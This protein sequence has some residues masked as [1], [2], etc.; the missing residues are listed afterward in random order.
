MT[1]VAQPLAPTAA[2]G[3][4]QGG[5]F[6]FGRFMRR[7]EPLLVVLS[8]AVFFFT[9]A[10]EPSFGQR[11][12]ISFLLADSMPLAV[13]AIGQTI[14]CLVRG[15]DLS[16][17]PI[18]GISCV[19]AGF[20][21]QDYGTSI[22]PLIP[23]GVGIGFGLG[24]LNGL[25][26]TYARIPPIVTTLGTLG[27][28]G[29]LQE[30]ICGS[31]E[32][33]VVP[34]TYHTLGNGDFLPDVP[35]LL[36]V[37]VVVMVVMAFALW[38]TPWGRALYAIGNNIDAA[39]RAGIRVNLVLVSAYAVCG[40]LAGLAGLAWLVHID[41][42]SSVT[43]SAESLQLWSIAAAMVGGVTLTGGKGGVIGAL[44]AAIFLDVCTNAT[45]VAGIPVI[46]NSASV[47]VL[48][49]IA[50]LI[51]YVQSG[52]YS[53]RQMF[54]GPLRARLAAERGGTSAGGAK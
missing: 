4:P 2:P 11:G 38:K 8:L 53:L 13:L 28:Y 7:R 27:I 46:W 35:Y 23:L 19:S 12:N 42:A 31:S 32:I 26:V 50:I 41:Y 37:G 49:I 36:I 48:L 33:N 9:Y 18:L 40:M 3:R 39:F 6:A 47:G 17:A 30:L 54:G 5:L 15:I 44:L 20:Y 51:D 52:G 43:G 14:V 10:L 29:G 21:A 25:F 34:P 24:L 16:V 45:L 22:W 1:G